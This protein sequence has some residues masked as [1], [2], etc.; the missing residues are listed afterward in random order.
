MIPDV[1]K[2]DMGAQA[3]KNESLRLLTGN[4]LVQERCSISPL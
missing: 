4:P 1:P 3:R 2:P